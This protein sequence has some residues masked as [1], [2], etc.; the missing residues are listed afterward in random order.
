M[1]KA[2]KS[3]GPKQ[4]EIPGT[5]RKKIPDVEEAFERFDEC[6]QEAAAAK[7]A[8]KAAYDAVIER[9]RDT[10]TKTYSFPMSD[11]T[12]VTLSLSDKTKLKVHKKKPE[13]FKDAGEED[14]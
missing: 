5:E 14:E 12:T 13:A 4:Q 7:N 10:K 6:K 2:K 8:E 9:M 3:K 1:A 11:G